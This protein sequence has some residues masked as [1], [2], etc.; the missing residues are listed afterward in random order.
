MLPPVTGLLKNIFLIANTIKYV[1]V[2]KYL[3][4]DIYL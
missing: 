2:R 4:I 3:N 1:A